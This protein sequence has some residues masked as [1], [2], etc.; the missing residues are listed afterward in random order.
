[1]RFHWQADRLSTL[2]ATD[3]SSAYRDAIESTRDTLA[4]RSK[5]Y[6]VLAAIVVL[7]IIGSMT[8]AVAS[9][10]FVPL[11][12]VLL[13]APACGLFFWLDARIVAA[14]RERLLSRWV[15]G[16]L[17]LRPGRSVILSIPRLPP[18]TLEAMV[19]TL[20]DE[21]VLKLL[22]N[23]SQPSRA[24]FTVVMAA[25][26]ARAPA[27]T[28]TATV[29]VSTLL[30]AIVMMIAL[31]SWTGGVAIAV[32]PLTGVAEGAVHRLRLRA[33]ARR[34]RSVHLMGEDVQALRRMMG[35]LDFSGMARTDHEWAVSLFS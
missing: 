13:L 1:M 7:T 27:R 8:A 32:I 22:D 35:V 23:L 5:S 10:S 2:P 21:H 26:H 24:V 30:G 14:W 20:P 9:R 6:R 19:A 29:M 4:H 33:I 25:L 16:Q 12:T 11:I 3:S 28:L 31:R 17:A 15:A 18:K 34:I